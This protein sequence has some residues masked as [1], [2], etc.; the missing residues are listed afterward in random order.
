M[1]I[2]YKTSKTGRPLKQAE[3]FTKH[4]HGIGLSQLDRDAVKIVTRLQSCGHDAYIVGGAVRD[5]L[6][7]KQPKDFDIATSAEP[8]QIRKIFRNSRIIGKRFRLA[9]IFF[10]NGKI[11][12]V[13]TFRK[14]DNSFGEIEDDALRR[15]FSVNALY[16][17]PVQEQLLDFVH[18]LVDISE[19][20]LRAIIPHKQI[21]IEDPVR[22]LR[23]IKYM[24]KTNLKPVPALHRRIR[25][26]C[27]LLQTVPQSRI[28]EE[29]YKILESGYASLIFAK[30]FDYEA[31][32]YILPRLNALI[33]GNETAMQG[34]FNNLA[35]LDKKAEGQCDRSDMIHYLVNDYI[36]RLAPLSDK[37]RLQFSELYTDIKEVLKPMSPANK[38][39]EKVVATLLRARGQGQR[40][41][42]RPGRRR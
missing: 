28:T 26:H 27:Q 22:M 13:S 19:R 4:E 17:D 15:D 18:G 20:R 39:V 36:S 8:A 5:I 41:P 31:M 29:I 37:K 21:F 9:H 7:K 16:F 42:R 12:E 3:I 40:M 11:I 2:R 32:N 38:D 6:L 33:R 30:L 14:G 10:H 24:I 35:I 34:F 23:A 25:R 1:L